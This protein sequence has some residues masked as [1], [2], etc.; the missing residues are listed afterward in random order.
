MESGEYS[1]ANQDEANQ[2]LAAR[3]S[4]LGAELAQTQG[5]ATALAVLAA[6]EGANVR[7]A[8]EVLLRGQENRLAQHI[9]DALDGKAHQKETVPPIPHL[10]VVSDK[11]E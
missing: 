9:L 3:I 8:L 1:F 10:T 2:F 5:L 4:D 7:S 6:K 11:S